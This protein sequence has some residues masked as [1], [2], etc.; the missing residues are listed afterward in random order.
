MYLQLLNGKVVN[1][2]YNNTNRQGGRNMP[3]MDRNFEYCHKIMKKYSKSFSYAFDLLPKAQRQAVWAIYAVCRK[4]DDSIDIYGDIQFL[5]QIKDDIKSIEV[6]P[7]GHHYFQ[8]D[9][10]MMLALQVVAQRY[11]INYQSFYNLIDTVYADQNFTQ[12]K[13]DDALLEYCYGVAGT[14][15]EVLTPILSHNPTEHTY[16]IARQLGEALQLINILRDVGEDFENGRIYFSEQRLKQYS[17]DIERQFN[18][19]VNA[20]YIH[21]WESYARLAQN[22]YQDVMKNIDVFNKEAQP[23]IELAAR[24]YRQILEEVRLQ[25]YT[26]H[27]RVYVNTSKKAKLYQQVN[28]KYKK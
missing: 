28:R 23:I 4:I 17:V 10:R 25:Q 12:F 13:T 20:N 15:G 24:L 27:E 3:M 6:K 18:D 9:R 19:G 1:I 8:S 11:P 22:D 2:R 16:D 5:N 26:L 14:V 21:L 7:Q